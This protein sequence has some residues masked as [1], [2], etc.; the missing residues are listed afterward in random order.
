[1]FRGKKICLANVLTNQDWMEISRFANHRSD[2]VG[3]KSHGASIAMRIKG[4][5][6]RDG[7]EN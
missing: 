2:G 5:P 3:N 1:M 4:M 7:D 6:K